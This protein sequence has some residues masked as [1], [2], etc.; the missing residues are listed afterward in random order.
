MELQTFTEKVVKALEEFYGPDA[1]IEAQQIYKNNGVK[2]Q[3]VCVLMAQ[4]NIAPTVYINH[5]FEQYKE[6]RE[7]GD[8]LSE[9]ITLYEENQ[10]YRK[11]DIDFFLD[12]GKVKKKLV[13]RL[14]HKGKNKELLKEIPYEE[15]NDLAVVCHCLIV[16]ESI[17]KGSVLIHRHH[18]RAWKISE[19][20]LFRAAKENSP[21]LQPYCL[22]P[23]SRMI[24]EIMERSI[25]DSVEE[26]CREYP[27]DKEAFLESTLSQMTD[28]IDR[29]RLPMYVLTNKDRYY[30]ASCILYE[31][32]LE[33]LAE[34]L[35]GDF[36]ILPSSV[37]ELILVEKQGEDKKEEYNQMVREVNA[38][39]VDIQEWLA[40]HAYLY[41]SKEN[42]VISLE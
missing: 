20:E 12:Y 40:N 29:C 30:G 17:G 11:L 21:R 26:I 15:F 23:M 7:F 6:G 39:H 41:V 25:E 28:E 19:K 33:E 22:Q 31:G 38:C 27:Q 37:H 35:R 4:K 42:R 18:L 1:R 13:L 3:G 32:I 2:L 9:I 10:V 5:F 8:I 16:N 36:Y 24:K 14:I 34:R